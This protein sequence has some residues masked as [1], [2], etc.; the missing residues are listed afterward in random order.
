ME[1]VK[2]ADISIRRR[3]L[4]LVYALVS[5]ECARCCHRSSI[6]ASDSELHLHRLVLLV[7]KAPIAVC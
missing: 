3:A 1:C 7:A 4:E 5:G 2:D 6:A